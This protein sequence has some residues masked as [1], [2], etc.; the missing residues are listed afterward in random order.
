M[1]LQVPA[2]AMPL[3]KKLACNT[4][5]VAMRK[6]LTVCYGMWLLLCSSTSTRAASTTT[7][8]CGTMALWA[9]TTEA[10]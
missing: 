8:L 10:R 9:C 6:T 5:G 2:D 3:F 4:I 7:P 1:M